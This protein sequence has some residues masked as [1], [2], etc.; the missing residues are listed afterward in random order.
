MGDAVMPKLESRGWTAK[1]PHIS[2][3]DAA[4]F[5]ARCTGSHTAQWR[6]RTTL[7]HDGAN[8]ELAD[9]IPIVGGTLTLDSSADPRRTLTVDVGGGDQWTPETYDDPLVPFGQYAHLYVR[10]DLA[11]G[12]WT[13]WLKLFEGP[14]RSNVFERP[15]L[16]TTI[17]CADASSFVEEY[18]HT[19]RQAYGG[20]SVGD[21]VRQMV[22]AALPG[23]LYDVDPADGED[24]PANNRQVGKFVAQAGDGRWTAANKLADRRGFDVFFDW[25][26]DLVIRKDITDNDDDTLP[27]QGPDIG[28][29]SSP[30][31]T[32]R[33]GI[34]GTMVGL[35]ATVTRDGAVNGV[36]VNIS[37]RVRNKH[38]Q[39][40][41]P[42]SFEHTWHHLEK[43]EAGSVT[44]GDRFG[45]LPLVISPNVDRI[46]DD[47]K[48]EQTDHA[49]HLLHRRRGLIR[50]LDIDAA[51]L[52][53][54]DTD[55]RVNIKFE[56]HTEKHYVQS[57]SFD[58]AGGPMHIRTRELSVTDPGDLGGTPAPAIDSLTERDVNTADMS[59]FDTAPIPW[60][61]A[62]PATTQIGDL[63]VLALS[64]DGWSLSD[65]RFTDYGHG[66][67]VGHATDLSD[68]P[69]VRTG[70]Y[71]GQ[72]TVV[73]FAEASAVVAA[74]SG[75][76]DVTTMPVVPG[77]QAAVACFQAVH[78]TVHGNYY[79]GSPWTPRGSATSGESSHVSYWSNPG[80][81][82]TPATAIS[83]GG[84]STYVTVIGLR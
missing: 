80:A 7:W 52:Y 19:K 51:P 72:A 76:A 59:F 36:A 84:S 8:H 12:S 67:Y 23:R 33:D 79:A 61:L 20:R 50:N 48:E 45:R 46:N 43:V 11:D 32:I 49:K 44:W 77:V 5:R 17:E 34:G 9:Y 10:I 14:I 58:L 24:A 68:I 64:P 30:V 56:G 41:E 2:A 66:A 75:A 83:G 29:H 31:A 25:N 71:W 65:A 4:D 74:V 27:A 21:A 37:S 13:P 78:G 82:S 42:A 39:K 53:W 16:V 40:G 57:V 1:T 70:N 28:T 69:L 15:S 62:L 73:S 22:D 38:R 55:D 26:G 3:D 81:T 54:L 47:I 60:P 63:L 6:L 35:A 18:L